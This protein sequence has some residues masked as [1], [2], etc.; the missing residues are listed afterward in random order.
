MATSG[1]K[2]LDD[3][4]DIVIP[5]GTVIAFAGTTVPNGWLLCDGSAVD[6]TAYSRLFS[7]IG[8]AHG[9]GNGSST[10]HIPDYRGQFLRG[11]MS[12]ISVTGSGTVASSN[13]TFTSHGINRTG[14]KV[15]LSSGTLSGLSASTDYYAIVVDANTLAFATSYAN[16]IAGTKIAI[17]GANSAV[18]VQW[19]S[20]DIASRVGAVGGNTGANIGS[21]QDNVLKSHNHVTND[22]DLGNGF[23]GGGNLVLNKSLG[24]VSGSTGGNETAPTNVSVNYLIRI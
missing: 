22:T 18:I 4:L 9:N 10:F 24:A 21:R 20:P 6:R 13:G 8:T 7:A 15:R 3:I 16:A 17:T 11:H 12:T 1:V 5:V 23:A 19:E 2:S 14:M